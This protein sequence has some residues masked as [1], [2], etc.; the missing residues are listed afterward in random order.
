MSLRRRM[1]GGIERDLRD[2]I[3]MAT[4]ENI[5]RGMP[6]DEARLAALR[7]FG[8]VLRV[9][10]DTRAVW[11]W[12]WA[13]RV[14]QDIRYTLRGLR[15]NP[16]FA[17]VAVLT[18]ALGIGMNSAVFSVVSTVLIKPLPYP[19]SGRIVWLANKSKHLGFETATAPD[20]ADWR[21]QARS[22]E[23]MAGYGTKDSTVQDGEQ[24][25][26]HLF[27]YTTPEFWRIA[28][29]RPALGRLFSDRDRDVMVLTWRMFQHRFHADPRAIGRMI[30]VDSRPTR[31][32]GVLP[33][34]FRFLLPS[35]PAGG[36][37]GEPEAFVP[38]I[39]TPEMLSR[40]GGLV[41]MF[42][43]GKLKPGVS[44]A[45]ARAEIQTIQ[46]RVA[47]QSPSMKLF[48]AG[49]ELR[50]LP[51]KEKL[52]GESRHALLI[53]LTAVGFVLLIACANLG[54]LLLAR[55]TA[56]Q[57]EIAIRAAIGAGRGRL[58]RH[59]LAEGLT[60]ALL[61]GAAG[62]ALARV[63]DALLIRLSPAAVPRLGEIGI[64]WRVAAF[65]LTISILAGVI[66][67]LAPAF[68]FSRGSLY[69]MLNEGGRA[70]SAGR[71]G[72]RVRRLLVAAE[73]ALALV[74]LT[75]AGLMVKSFARMY[76]H[77]SS[78]QPA[79]IGMMKVYL[80][81]PAYREQTV[82]V[83][84]AG[85]ALDRIGRIPGVRATAVTS[86]FAFGAATIDGMSFPP[87]Q[88]PM[89]RFRNASSGYPR[90]IGLSLLRGRWTTDDETPPA[91][92]VNETLV[93]R[94]FGTGDPLGRRIVVF[95]KPY[96]IVGVASDLKISRLDA[97]V[98]P[99]VLIPY[100]Y[101]DM[102][103]RM[104]ILVKTAG[105][106]AAI[107]PEVRKAIARLDPSQ[108]PYGVTTLEDALAESIAPQRFNLILLGTFAASAVL[109]ALIG[110]YG[111]MSYAVTQRTHEIGVRMALGARRSEIVRMVVAQGMAV[112]AIGIAAGT[113]AA[114]GLTRLMASLLFEVKPTDPFTFLAAAMGLAATSLLASWVPA[115]RAARVDPLLALR[116]E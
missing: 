5:A 107:L 19:D 61:G 88:A 98:E 86:A 22:F 80:M 34:N 97:D 74:L 99:E 21:E 40:A 54:N 89:V 91:V 23:A 96:E 69:S 77:P 32:I 109:L 105:D 57:R 18:L 78:F 7:K 47:H 37:S 66:F 51:L 104:D 75:G 90:V 100:K 62:L 14:M 101:A 72:L 50:V 33:N 111:V 60:L 27:V 55:A 15:R 13:E 114:M 6:P 82:E 2:H 8:N 36:I 52:V 81:G 110:I 38:N 31:I 9:A 35:A 48:Y 28:G 116:Y 95:G 112:A 83:A 46:G 42:I 16:V 41:M 20:F 65:A 59:F 44:V 64:D 25:A 79:Q 29:A 73:L 45:Q 85:R 56:R 84:Y 70:A 4:E 49:A 67:G 92:M 103:R 30:L 10:E 11:R 68:S 12:A 26:K 94:V 87:G 102:F 113:A 108:P 115:R 58:L 3:E 1:E 53:L 39:V 71:G 106:P 93:W 76:T 17:A 63:A 43:A 24:S